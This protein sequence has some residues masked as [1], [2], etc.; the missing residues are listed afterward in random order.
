MKGG[1]LKLLQIYNV[2]QQKVNNFTNTNLDQRV[3]QLEIQ[4]TE[5]QNVVNNIPK[6]DQKILLDTVNS[7]T[8]KV[9]SLEQSFKNSEFYFLENGNIKELVQQ[10]VD[11]LEILLSKSERRYTKC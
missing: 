11:K 4:I 2:S 6:N 9:N 3:S 1:V 7:L 5:L 10:E 8:E